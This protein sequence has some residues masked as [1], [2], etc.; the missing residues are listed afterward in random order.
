MAETLWDKSK[1]EVLMDINEREDLFFLI[2]YLV[3]PSINNGAKTKARM[4]PIEVL[5]K[6]TENR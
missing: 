6:F 3:I 2:K 4:V 5:T 1:R